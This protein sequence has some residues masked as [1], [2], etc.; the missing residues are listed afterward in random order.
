MTDANNGNSPSKKDR[1]KKPRPV[2]FV[3]VGL[4]I[5]TNDCLSRVISATT[6]EQA[7]QQFLQETSFPA[8]HIHGPF[9]H[10]RTQVLKTTQTLRFADQPAK[11]A[12]YREW[13]VNSFLLTEPENHAYLIFLNRTDGK[14]QTAPQGTIIVSTTELRF[15]S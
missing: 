5:K 15:L 1:Q 9:L 3:C 7:A 11:P 14:Q 6:P 4:D 13:K 8:K 12:I 2:V 10:K